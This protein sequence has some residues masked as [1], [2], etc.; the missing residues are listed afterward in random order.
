MLLIAQSGLQPLC[1]ALCLYNRIYRAL[2]VTFSLILIAFA[3]YI[4]YLIVAAL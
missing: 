2:C 1:C 3:G 4:V